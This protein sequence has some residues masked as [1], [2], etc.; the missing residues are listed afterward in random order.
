[1]KRGFETVLC[2]VDFSPL[3]ERAFELAVAVCQKTGARLVLH[4]NL[5]TRPPNFLTVSWM[6]SEDHEAAE[7]ELAAS[8][9][10]RL[11]ELFTRI[12]EGVEYEAKITR[13]PTDT[14]LLYLADELPA[15]LIIMGTHGVSDAEHQSLTEEK[16]YGE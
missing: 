4:H 11:E 2:P 12:P 15:D 14:A 9:P 6:W 5:G 8:A 16:G 1:M 10:D 3:S 13:A 7:E